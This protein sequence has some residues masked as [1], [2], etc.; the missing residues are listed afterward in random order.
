M[1]IIDTIKPHDGIIEND[2]FV[3]A[4]GDHGAAWINKDAIT[5]NAHLML[6]LTKA[7]ADAI[8]AQALD[9]DIICGPAIG[10]LIIS[11]YLGQHL[12]KPSIYAERTNTTT[13]DFFFKRNFDALIKGKRV[14]LCDDVINTGYSLEKTKA[15]IIKEGGTVCA[16]AALINRGNVNTDL[17]KVPLIYL[18]TYEMP[19]WP[20]EKCPLCEEKVPINPNFAHG[21]TY[22]AHSL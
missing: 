1:N 18:A 16:G 21:S 2:H 12:N 13:K 17:L 15:A 4:S 20:A 8:N 14:L 10:G 5:P 7:L 3:Y 6:Q 19:S 22:A 11:Q 9:V